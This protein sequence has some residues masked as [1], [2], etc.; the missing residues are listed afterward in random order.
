MPPPELGG[1]RLRACGVQ[2][3][4]GGLGPCTCTARPMAARP[5]SLSPVL[6]NTRLMPC[7]RLVTA[8]STR[9]GGRDPQVPP[10][11]LTGRG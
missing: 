1:P 9:Q 8:S 3:G 6:V 4:G 2:A 10:L 5:D 7:Q 11:M